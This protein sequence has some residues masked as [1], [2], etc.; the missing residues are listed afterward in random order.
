LENKNHPMDILHIIVM[1]TMTCI[2]NLDVRGIIKGEFVSDMA[3]I[4]VYLA[5][6][7]SRHSK[8]AAELRGCASDHVHMP[9]GA[10]TF[11]F[12]LKD[13]GPAT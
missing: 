1:L 5:D 13:I 10:K 12:S 6:I 11:A 7:I 8:L 3:I 2:N 4:K 9:P